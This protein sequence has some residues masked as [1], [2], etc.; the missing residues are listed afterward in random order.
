MAVS[1]GFTDYVVEQLE[2][3]GVIST[4]RMFGAVGIYCGETFFALIDDDILY[5]KV[6]D[7]T[8]PDFER[9]GSAP[10]RPYGDDRETMQYFSV[11]VSV[12]E[13]ASELTK[14]GR[15]ALEAAQRKKAISRP[16]SKSR[17][18][19]RSSSGKSSRRR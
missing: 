13:D 7:I 8:R 4:R 10:F 16:A 17:A 3:C 12:L 19:S 18:R 15:K 5:L 2:G 6:D 1:Q 11:P 14:W 9:I